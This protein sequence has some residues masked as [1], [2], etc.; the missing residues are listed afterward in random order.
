MNNVQVQRFFKGGEIVIVMQKSV[1]V[2]QADAQGP[3]CDWRA[4]HRDCLPTEFS[5]AGIECL[6]EPSPES[7]VAALLQPLHVW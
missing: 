3:V 5:H 4:F 1:S 7:E 6:P 2:H